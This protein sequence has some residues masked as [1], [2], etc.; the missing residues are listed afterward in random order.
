MT[1]EYDADLDEARR[2]WIVVHQGI[3]AIQRRRAEVLGRR[4]R[5]LQRVSADAA[6]DPHDDTNIPPIWFR[7]AK[8]PASRLELIAVTLAA[9]VAPVGWLGGWLLNR[10]IARMIPGCLRAYPIAALLWSG[11]AIGVVLVAMY[12]P[13]PTTLSIVIAPWVCVQ[14]AVIPTVAGIYGVLDGWLAV[15]GSDQWWPLTPRRR[16]IT[17]AEAA[18]ILGG[19]TNDPAE[20]LPSRATLADG[21]SRLTR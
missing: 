18:A 9:V 10:A 8:S 2:A 6:P 4:L 3:S 12:H 21:D 19:Y 15:P 16:P 1:V 20:G 13:T 17:A 14:I 7:S 11:V 5:A